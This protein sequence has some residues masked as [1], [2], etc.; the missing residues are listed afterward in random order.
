MSPELAQLVRKLLIRPNDLEVL[1]VPGLVQGLSVSPI[2]ANFYLSQLDLAL[3]NEG[4]SMIRFADDFAISSESDAEAKRALEI[5]RNKTRDVGLEL[6]ASKTIIS[7][8]EQGIHFLGRTLTKVTP[9]PQ[10]ERAAPP[11]GRALYV[12]EQGSGIRVRNHH[13]VVAK[14][15]TT[16]LDVPVRQVASITL[17]GAVGLSAQARSLALATSLPVSFLSR[18]GRWLGRLDSSSV[19]DAARRRKQFMLSDDE[20][21]CL[22]FARSAIAGKIANQR[23]L[24]LR[25]Q[26][27]D[28]AEEVASSVVTLEKARRSAIGASSIKSLRGI[29]GS[30]AKSYFAGMRYCLPK[31]LGF[32]KRQAYPPTDP[33]NSLLSLGYSLLLGA[34]LTDLHLAGLDPACGIV[35]DDGLRP[36]LA[37]DLMEEFR[38]LVVDS[39]VVS[40]LR[41]RI[42]KRSSFE[43]ESTGRCILRHEPLRRFL[44]MFEERLQTRVT[45]LPTNKKTSYRR[46][47]SLQVASFVSFLEKGESYEPM[48]WR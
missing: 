3:M 25:Y 13:F 48:P 11:V 2:L 7:T 24:L 14:D 39:L 42:F 43:K 44:E 9:D 8:Y 15:S 40:A 4:L 5:L 32:E 12:T 16:L 17:V 27:R 45:H 18:R 29:E 28:H 33:V 1:R 38:P 30:A 37:C 36:S 23:S 46:C 10:I 31:G 20:D 47:I 26:W 6:N 34:V 21:V 35:H 22:R 41:R 19:T